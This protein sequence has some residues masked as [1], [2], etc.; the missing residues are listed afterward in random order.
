M[1]VNGSVSLSQHAP[2][3]NAVSS[4]GGGGAVDTLNNGVVSGVVYRKL[5][6]GIDEANATP[7]TGCGDESVAAGI[8][9]D[10]FDD[11]SV[12]FGGG[13]A[14]GGLVRDK[15]G[16]VIRTC[17]I[18]GCQY[19]GRSSYMKT[20]KAA[21]HGIDV[22]WFSCDQ[23]RCEY[24]AKEAGDLKRHKQMIH[25]IDVRWHHCDQDGCDYKAKTFMILTFNGT[26]V[27]KTDATIRQS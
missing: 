19:R 23:D 11:G 18:A 26:T 27:I 9:E 8:T 4:S 3:S 17:G 1:S 22:V 10:D 15:W 20:H 24:K 16:K 2:G 21:K 13:G 25:D 12:I 7:T 5:L 14:G 6:F